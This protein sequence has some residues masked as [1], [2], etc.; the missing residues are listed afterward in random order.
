VSPSRSLAAVA[1]LGVAAG[2]FT[3]LPGAT[4]KAA[5][6]TL[7][8]YT[9]CDELLAY[10]RT[11]LA[12]TT[13]AYDSFPLPPGRPGRRESTAVAAAE[14]SAAVPDAVGSG[15]TG[16]N[17]QERGVDEPDSAKLVG[18]L[19]FTF[20][21]DS[22]QIVRAGTTPDLLASFPLGAPAYGAELIVQDGRVLVLLPGGGAVDKGGPAGISMPSPIGGGGTK[23]L[24]LDIADP[25]EPALLE[26]LDLDGRYLSARL[27]GGAVRLV[28][29][30]TPA[31]PIPS[32]SYARE[33]DAA[34]ARRAAA[35]SATLADVLPQAVR[36]TATGSVVS[37][38]P[39][40]GC[41]QVRHAATP[42]GAGT[43][44]VTTLDLTKGLAAQDSTAVTTEGDLVY[45]AADRLY[46]ATS[47][48]GMSAPAASAPLADR[49]S[50]VTTELHAFDTTDPT[51]TPY[52][53]SAS[54]AGYVYGRWA[55]SSYDGHLR[56][57]T[58]NSPPWGDGPASSSRV[59]VLA[60][61]EDGLVETGRVDGLGPGERI[62]AVRYFGELATVVTFRQT[63]PLYVLDLADPAAP[64]LLGELKVPGFSTYLHPVGDDRLLGVGQDADSSGRVTGL[65]VSLFDLSD[66]SRPVQLDR[67]P[68]GTGHSLALEDSRAFGYDPERRLALLPVSTY[69]EVTGRN[70]AVGVRVGAN[71]SLERAGRLALGPDVQVERV[72]HDRDNIYAVART[73]VV[74]ARAGDFARTGS[75]A[76]PR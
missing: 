4:P 31:L 39:A 68:L 46:V 36:R 50:D 44:L 2:A 9:G 33:D 54:V 60:E 32:Q 17:V 62:Y 22:L 51:S 26:S 7:V 61:R 40:V 19:L 42:Q 24:L 48:W 28:T 1:V 3:L 64:R 41:G 52:A 13:S 29:A 58:T 49:S 45:A 20:S 27:S 23:L 59:T 71:G 66:L 55:L 65:Q 63:D 75:V 72:L 37:D 8:P 53:G 67:L 12:K 43:L 14:G 70:E 5:A 56:V 6:D 25:S 16:T 35:R 57:A 11:E 21:G 74:A 15:P 73:G 69:D 30:S 34:N 38:G 10:Y 47:R 18:D 76:F